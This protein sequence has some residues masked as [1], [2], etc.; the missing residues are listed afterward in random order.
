MSNYTKLYWLTRLDGLNGFLIF[1]CI[2]AATIASLYT[3]GVFSCLEEGEKESKKNKKARIISYIM[4]FL[5]VLISV[6]TPTK[7]EAVF[8]VA[9]GKV[10]DFVQKDSSINKIPGQTTSILSTWLDEQ[11]KKEKDKLLSDNTKVNK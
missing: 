5:F 4:F 2:C 10:I 8:I 6:L 11:L 3:I 1:I 9:G 7:E